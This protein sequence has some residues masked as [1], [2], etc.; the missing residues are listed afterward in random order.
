[1][2]KKKKLTVKDLVFLGIMST[3]ALVMSFIVGIAT[4][5]ALAFSFISGAGLSVMFMT[6]PY[7]LMAYKVGKRGIFIV[8]SL[9]NAL[10]YLLVGFPSMIII[11]LPLGIICELI[12]FKEGSYRNLKMNVLVWSL[13]GGIYS[14]HGVILLWVM[15]K[16]TF[17]EVFS[18][19]FTDSHFE[20]ISRYYYNPYILLIIF[21]LGAIGALLGSFISWKLLKKHFIKAGVVRA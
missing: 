5:P 4:S 19:M 3:L 17:K 15:G 14:L 10:L 20:L 8:Y 11:A 12:M 1:M 21:A 2:N 7:F 9:V 6:L 18:N 16:H 13:Y